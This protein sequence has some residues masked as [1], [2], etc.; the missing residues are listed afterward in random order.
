MGLKI[1]YYQ[2]LSEN[3]NADCTKA[4]VKLIDRM[5]LNKITS[6]I[7]NT[8]IK[9]EY[10]KQFCLDLIRAR[11]ELVIDQAYNHIKSPSILTCSEKLND[12]DE[13]DC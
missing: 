8:P 13:F 6:I 12:Y 9:H 4:L 3:I 7:K 10:Y 11:K 1:N 2:F 5:D